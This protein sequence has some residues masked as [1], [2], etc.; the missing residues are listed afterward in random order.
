[1]KK[2]VLLLAGL[3]ISIFVSA[4]KHA[5]WI[6]AAVFYQIYPS[7]FQDS[8]GNGIGDLKG[9]Q[10]RLDY[11]QSLGVNTIWLN[12]IFKSGF[13]DGGYDVI[14]FYQ[15]DPRFGTNTE[16]VQLANEIHRRGMHMVLD[17]VAGH[18]SNQSA[19]F[20]QSMEA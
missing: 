14:D 9:I 11:V 18:S 2:P 3:L 1:M 20:R 15:V 13:K 7:S 17:L 8:D 5:D 10:S 16:L 19:W 12:P 4:Q 6:K